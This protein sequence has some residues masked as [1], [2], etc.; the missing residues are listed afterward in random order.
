MNRSKAVKYASFALLWAAVGAYVLCAAGAARRHRHAQRVERLTVEIADS[1]D[2]GCLVTGDM[3]RRW[4]GRNKLATVGEPVDKV[5]LGDLERMIRRHGFV[6][7]VSAWITYGGELKI[8]IRQRRPVLRLLTDGYDHYMT[9]E[10]YLFAAPPLTSLYVPVVT[11]SYRP[12]VATGFTGSLDAELARR[13]A[14]HLRRMEEMEREKYPCYDRQKEERE[15]Y[16]EVMRKS[17]KRRLFEGDAAYEQRKKA[18]AGEKK[19]A[20]RR[21][22]YRLQL[23]AR[24]IE[25][26]EARREAERRAQKKL[27]KNFADFAKLTTFVKFIEADDFWGSEIVQIVASTAA[28]GA[29]ELEL[30]PRSGRH[31]IRFGEIVDVERKFDKLMRFYRGGLGN[32][33]WEEFRTIDVAYGGQ[34]VCRK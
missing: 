14:E 34:V 15:A 12:P 6:D 19:L 9:A 31:T 1:T 26:I 20:L 4:I 22:R 24:R 30:I 29:L 33:G 23:I 10:G 13:R 28:S 17:S 25:A 3:V 11:G 18:L 7:C 21:Y 32:I 27:E 5:K 2:R 8:S 16:R